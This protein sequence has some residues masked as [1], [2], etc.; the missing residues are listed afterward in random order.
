[1]TGE[2]TSETAFFGYIRFI[3]GGSMQKVPS[4]AEGLLAQEGQSGESSLL[5]DRRHFLGLSATAAASA[6]VVLAGW[7]D[8]AYAA[9]GDHVL[10]IVHT[11]DVHSY[12][13]VLPYVKGLA[14]Q[15]K[16]D[17]GDANETLV[18]SA[19]DDFAGTAFASLSAG[20]DVAEAMNLTAYDMFTV[21]NHEYMMKAPAF[22]AVVD[23][24]SFSVLG[25]NVSVATAA[26]NPTIAPYEV[27]EFYG[28]KIAFIGITYN[29]SDSP[30]LISSVEAARDAA[31]LNDGATV[32]IGIAHLGLAEADV[33]L[34]STH[35]AATC[36]WLTAIIDGHSHT[37]LADG[38]LENGVLI[39]QTGEYGNNIGVT[40]ITI[41]SSGVVVGK[42]AKLIAIKGNEASCG[43]VPDA[44]VQAFIAGVNARNEAYINEVVL[45]LPSVLYGERQYSRTQETVFGNLIADSMSAATGTDIAMLAGPYIR[46]NLN[47]GDVTRGQ[48][49]AALYED[50][51]LVT[52]GISGTKILSILEAGLASYPGENNKFPHMSGM[53]V[54]FD[55]ALPAESRVIRVVM[56]DGSELDL[57]TTYSCTIRENMLSTYLETAEPYIEGTHYESGWGTICEAFAAHLNSGI[58]VPEE[59]D[60]RMRPRGASYAIH[61][62]GNGAGT[63]IVDSIVTPYDVEATLPA[64]AFS[65]EGY[66][67]VAWADAEGNTY[68]A[69]A[70]V[71]NLDILANGEITLFAQWQKDADPAVV[72]PLPSDPSTSTKLPGS[73]LPATG[74]AAST[75]VAASL[76]AAAGAGVVA[77][78]AMNSAEKHEEK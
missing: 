26:D 69:G 7:G 41:D 70:T 20:Q 53:R 64:N 66:S 56:A 17:D 6:A 46:T 35:V 74:D 75:L 73:N 39:A 36:P 31:V 14:D 19:G 24:V 38:M 32:F 5:L 45:T 61:F 40:E 37:E 27:R 18:I 25:C 52:V 12:V 3:K 11:N 2:S 49:E 63:G 48:L 43:I 67:F 30:D 60:G 1:M 10:T 77:Y 59:I 76:V 51:D 62:D 22:Q 55:P 58:V 4:R 72:T 16:A 21:G 54:V 47:A 13:D 50:V 28:T 42:V 23:A 8:Y 78:G 44:G 34:R 65:R 33:N 57:S 71:M 29:W 15:L 9:P 68:A